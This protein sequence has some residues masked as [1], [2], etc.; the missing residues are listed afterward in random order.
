MAE[1]FLQDLGAGAFGHGL[2]DDVADFVGEESVAPEDLHVGWLVEKVGLMWDDDA[3][4]PVAV[5]E[6]DEGAGAGFVACCYFER[7]EEFG[8]FERYGEGKP[9]AFCGACVEVG[10]IAKG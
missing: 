6:G 1:Q 5:F 3:H 10:W 9:V 2:G 4:E 8:V 7:G